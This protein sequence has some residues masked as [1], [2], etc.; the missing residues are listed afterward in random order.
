MM[1]CRPNMDPDED[2]NT[3]GTLPRSVFSGSKQQ[4]KQLEK[5]GLHDVAEALRNAKV[6]YFNGS[7]NSMEYAENSERSAQNSRTN[8]D[9]I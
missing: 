1:L 8:S 9:C 6:D 5:S 3:H 4:L 2:C 7:V